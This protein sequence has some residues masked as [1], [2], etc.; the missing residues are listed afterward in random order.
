MIDLGSSTYVLYMNTFKRLKLD[1]NDL[2]LFRGTLVNFSSKQALIKDY[3]TF[4]MVFGLKKNAQMI[5]FMYLVI[6]AP[7][8][9]NIIIGRPNINLIKPSQSTFHLSIKYLLDNGKLGVV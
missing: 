9:Y 1:P 8:S 3:I 2:H 7:S 6:N 5:K 4:K